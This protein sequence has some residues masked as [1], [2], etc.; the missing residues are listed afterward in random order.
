MG[1]LGEHLKTRL[2]IMAAVVSLVMS[3]SFW[4]CG[5]G[6][7]PPE[8]AAAAPLKLLVTKIDKYARI[9]ARKADGGR[10]LV[11][12]TNME[13]ASQGDMTLMSADFMLQNITDNPAEKYQ[14]AMENGLSFE[15]KNQFGD[16]TA[17]K[18][19]GITDLVHPKFKVDKILIFALPQDADPTKYEIFYKPLELKFPLASAETEVVDHGDTLPPPPVNNGTGTSAA[20]SPAPIAPITP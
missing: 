19:L 5:G 8:Q 15:F 14:Q 13:N 6:D 9:G 16:E 17:N 3:T 7:A 10:F 12:Q 11:V 2:G 18:L 1:R 20:P 4:G